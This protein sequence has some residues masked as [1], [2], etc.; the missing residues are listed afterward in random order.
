M[1]DEVKKLSFNDMGFKFMAAYGHYSKK[2]DEADNDKERIELNTLITQLYS[3]EISYQDYYE[4]IDKDV[5]DRSR[6]Y[7]SKI[8]T[9]RKF[10]YRRREQ[11]ADRIS[12]HK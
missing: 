7:R 5:R 2:F 12:R 10:E 11:K 9:S 6:F 8:N 1:S 3:N 4:K